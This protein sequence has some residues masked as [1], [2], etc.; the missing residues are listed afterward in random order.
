[1]TETMSILERGE[2]VQARIASACERVG[3][4]PEKVRLVAVSKKQPPEAV[5]EAAQAGL[6]LFGENRVQEAMHKIPECRGGVSWH[7]IG[8]L[9]TNKVKPAVQL[10]SRVTWT[11]LVPKYR[12]ISPTRKRVMNRDGRFLPAR[13]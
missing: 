1:M 13:L 5:E 2:Q 3:R 11:R 7:L 4:S 8:H 12:C 9:Q 10:H 6:L